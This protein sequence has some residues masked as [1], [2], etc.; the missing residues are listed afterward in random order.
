[1]KPSLSRVCV[2]AVSMTI[3]N[4]ATRAADAASAPEIRTPPAPQTPRINGPAVFG[5]RPGH[6]LLYHIPASGGR[7]ISFSADHLPP[8]LVLD[9]SL[10]NLTGSLASAGEYH[11]IL[12]A[13]N[14][15]GAAEKP[16]KIV[17]GETLALTPPLGWNSWNHYADKVS[18]E[19]VLQNAR[20]MSN[21]G[22]IDH[23]WTYVNIDD[24]WQGR[25]GGKFNAI[26]GNE[27]FPDMKRLADSVHALGL[28]LGIYSTPWTTSYADQIGGSSESA[29]GAWSPPTVSKDGR[30]NNKTL[31]WAIG[32]FS[33]ASN[34]A[35][36]WAAWGIDYL[37]YDWNP[38]EVRETQQMYAALRN[39]GRDVVL[40][41]SNSTPFRNA[42]TLARFANCW[43]TG[44]DIS[45]NW[46]SMCRNG[47]DLEN[48]RPLAGPGHWNDTDMLEI[49][50]HPPG[51]TGLTP[52]EEYTHMTLWCLLSAPLL[53]GN[54]LSQ[55]DAFTLNL[56]DNDEVLA[57]DQDEL[58]RQAACVIKTDHMRVFI[59]KLADGSQAVGLFNLGSDNPAKVSVS[60]AAMGLSGKHKVRDLW[61]QKNL[62]SFAETFSLPVAA[63][64]AEL[65]KVFP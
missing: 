41:L 47:F 58:G 27:K 16:L 2:I 4:W 37:K 28:K 6:P 39:S 15:Y 26:Q 21:S 17:V 63:H 33:F 50:N 55:L 18:Q 42:A 19:I 65:I 30:I 1:M 10:G 9:A 45:P 46:P 64:G 35:A 11:V 48:W 8:G 29:D 61:R 62:G 20:A 56:L 44:D 22:L 32:R 23:G 3:A 25:R 53:L 14:S 7:P 60:W 40:S 13:S 43:R 57:V 24:T 59:K 54:D 52:D 34:D 12:R 36:Q 5:V 51:Q 49:G 31:P 38:I